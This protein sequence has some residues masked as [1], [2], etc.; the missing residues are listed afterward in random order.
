[1][2]AAQAVSFVLWLLVCIYVEFGVYVG[3][4]IILQDDCLFGVVLVQ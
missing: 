4:N 1:M 2:E 3:S